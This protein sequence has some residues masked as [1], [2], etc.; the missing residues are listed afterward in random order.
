MYVKLYEVY[1]WILVLGSRGKC[2]RAIHVNKI[3]KKKKKK[4]KSLGCWRTMLTQGMSRLVEIIGKMIGS[5]WWMRN[6]LI[7]PWQEY[8]SQ[9]CPWSP[10]ID[11]K[12]D[13]SNEAIRDT[14]NYYRCNVSIRPLADLW[15]VE[16][17]LSDKPSDNPRSQIIT[18]S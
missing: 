16:F 2:K 14:V 3:F 17:A 5:L 6:R 12:V 8:I 11:N 18:F 10:D 9:W 1:I 13:D 15:I 4:K 7:Q